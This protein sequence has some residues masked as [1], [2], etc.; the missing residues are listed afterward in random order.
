MKF[1][2]FMNVLRLSQLTCLNPSS[3]C[4]IVIPASRTPNPCLSLHHPTWNG[5]SDLL[6]AYQRRV[7]C[8][9]GWR[10]MCSAAVLNCCQGTTCSPLILLPVCW[11]AAVAQWNAAPGAYSVNTD[12]CISPSPFPIRPARIVL[13]NLARS[14]CPLWKKK[15]LPLPT[16]FVMLFLHHRGSCSRELLFSLLLILPIIIWIFVKKPS[17]SAVFV[18]QDNYWQP[19][20]NLTVSSRSLPSFLS[21]PNTL[22]LY[23]TWTQAI[24]CYFL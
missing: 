15:G 16:H 9:S 10:D 20:C 8:K 19:K 4:S 12:Y 7:C 1:W 11:P 17:D 3:R 6:S 23:A 14:W 5:R 2:W 18:F 24:D 13:N 22:R 21:L